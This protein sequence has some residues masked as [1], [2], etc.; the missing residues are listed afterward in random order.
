MECINCLFHFDDINYK[1]SIM[2]D[3]EE[4]ASLEDFLQALSHHEDLK[5][6]DFVQDFFIF[7]IFDSELNEYVRFES[8][9]RI[10][11]MSKIRVQILDMDEI[12]S[13]R[14][15]ANEADHDQSEDLRE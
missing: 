5:R 13:S 8:D 12:I 6:Y 7:E 10:T 9:T 11:D 15:M 3:C 14:T 4:A 1:I 2:K